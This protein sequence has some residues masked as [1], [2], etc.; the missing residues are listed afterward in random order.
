MAN[1]LVLGG[2]GLIGSFIAEQLASQGHSVKA[3][4]RF[5]GQDNLKNAAGVEKVKGDYL[6]R[7][8]V[9]KALE[10]IEIVFH[11]LHTTVPV[12]SIKD[13]LHDA[14][15]NILPAIG[16]LEDCVGAGV[17][18]FVYLSSIAVYGIP[19]KS[20]IGEDAK[21]IPVSPYGVSK[22]AIEEY[23]KYFGRAKGLGFVIV[24][25]SATYGE[26]QVLSPETGVV[27]NFVFNALKKQALSIRGKGEAVRD[28]T[29]GEDIA[30]GVLKAAFTDA[31]SK[32]FNLGTGKGISLNKLAEKVGEAVGEKPEIKYEGS[33]RGIQEHVYDVSRAK[34]ELGWEAEIEIAEGL[35]RCVEKFKEVI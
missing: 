11:S 29:H 20:P 10:G 9:K 14:E 2:N 6:K 30:K 3:F 35:K 12:S 28:L 8:Q 5:N 19:E 27:A 17:K 4:D 7:E 23:V 32:I 24:R 22:L 18:K 26:R 33:S 31:K 34:E 16:L 13:P 21:T 1:C 15:T 25:P